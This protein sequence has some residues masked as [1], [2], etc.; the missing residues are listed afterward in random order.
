MFRKFNFY[1]ISL[2]IGLALY[3]TYI[4]TLLDSIKC[5][6]NQAVNGGRL[7]IC[8]CRRSGVRIPSP[9]LNIIG[10]SYFLLGSV[11]AYIFLIHTPLLSCGQESSDGLQ[12]LLFAVL[13][14][15]KIIA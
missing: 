3:V 11:F 4:F 15:L 5:G 6:S 13:C 8:S 12:F 1:R 2:P 9:A 7:K 10:F 14:G